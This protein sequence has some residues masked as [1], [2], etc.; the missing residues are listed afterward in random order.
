MTSQSI[1]N[2][3]TMTRPLWREHVISNS[4]DID[5]V[6]GDYHGRSCKNTLSTLLFLCGFPSQGTSIAGLWYFPWFHLYKLSNKQSGCRWFQATCCSRDITVINPSN[7]PAVW[8]CCKPRTQ[9]QCSFQ[10]EAA[11]SLANRLATASDRCS[12]T[13]VVI[14]VKWT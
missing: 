10:M 9:W 1:G 5:F 6:H 2:D 3:V 7:H 12:N 11:L 14:P 8:R 4:L 13:V